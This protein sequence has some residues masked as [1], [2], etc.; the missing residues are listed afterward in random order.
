VDPVAADIAA[1]LAPDRDSEPYRLAAAMLSGE[2]AF[3]MAFIEAF[4]A[5]KF[6]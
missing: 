2:D 5:G 6:A 1:A 3:G 4:R